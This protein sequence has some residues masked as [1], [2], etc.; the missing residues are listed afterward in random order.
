MKPELAYIRQMIN[1][2]CERKAL[3]CTP[4]FETFLFGFLKERFKHSD[5][6]FAEGVSK[7]YRMRPNEL[8]MAIE[9]AIFRYKSKNVKR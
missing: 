1:K 9:D 3:A 6:N 2:V 7:T 5:E 8:E 4:E